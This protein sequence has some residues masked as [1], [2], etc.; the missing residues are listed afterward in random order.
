MSEIFVTANE[1]SKIIGRTL[2]QVIKDIK[3]GR[4][5][6]IVSDDGIQIPLSQFYSH[7]WDQMK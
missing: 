4:I 7:S 5:K 1:L 3:N 6:A 2:P